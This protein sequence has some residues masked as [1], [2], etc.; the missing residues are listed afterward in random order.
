M[1]KG[2]VL[3]ATVK[4]HD[5][6]FLSCPD[7]DSSLNGTIE[8]RYLQNGI[9]N[10]YD[11]FYMKLSKASNSWTLHDLKNSKKIS[12]LQVKSNTLFGVLTG[13]KEIYPKDDPQ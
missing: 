12:K 13:V 4:G 1:S 7:C 11:S 9:T 2:N 6:I 10:S 3:V 5:A 8:M